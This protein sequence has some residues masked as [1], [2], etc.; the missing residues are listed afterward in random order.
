MLL[1]GKHIILGITGSIA[2][3]KAAQLVR[4]LI[5]EGAEVKVVM[6]PLAKEFITPV[7][8]ATLSKNPVL[9]DFFHRP[10]GHWNSHVDLG[11]WADLLLIAPSSAN[12]MAKMAHG[13]CDNLL[14]TTYL[15]VRCPV[16]FAPAMDFDMFAHPATRQNL[17][18]LKSY[19]NMI[20]EPV[21]GELASGLSGKGRME[22]PENILTEVIKFFDS[23]KKLKNKR[24]I[25]TAGPTVEAIDPV[26]FISNHSSG[27]M[28]YSIANCLAEQGAEVILIS[29]PVQKQELHGSIK[30]L[31]VVSAA[32][33]Y[34]TTTKWFGKA[35][36]AILAAAV[37]D[38]TPAE[39]SEI[40]IKHAKQSLNI[41]LKPTQDI[42]GYLGSVKKD[43]QVLIG[44]AL[45]TN[46][47]V[48]NAKQKLQQKNLD[49]IVL[50]SL[51]DRDACF[52]TVTNKVTFIDKNNKIRKF[53]LK[54]KS[55]VAK[56][57]VNE[58]IKLLS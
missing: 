9:C 40:K 43:K 18:I 37:A 23:K 16:M 21:S 39:V 27:K 58:L 5:K 44:F 42:A 20:L 15:S 49:L 38:F 48:K 2:A 33:M 14:L 29:G 54:H 28:G 8:L 6:T 47:E 41:Q 11:I 46:N 36:A 35:D 26:R 52:G 22:E 30:L 13:V 1:K 19:G 45:E 55:E 12:T 32:E 17:K 50:N 24:I 53:E 56:D 31:H 4:L 51:N 57:I 7:T 25:I 10:D 3:Y 34:R